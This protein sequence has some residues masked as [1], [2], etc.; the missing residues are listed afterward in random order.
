MKTIVVL[1]DKELSQK[2]NAINQDITN[3]GLR[4]GLKA[5]GLLMTGYVK[6]NI[7]EQKLVD[8]GN[9]LNS[10][11]LKDVALYDGGGYVNVGT[12]VVYARIHEFGGVIKPVRAKMLSWIDKETGK[13]IFAHK[14]VIP[15]RPYMRPAIESHK[16]DV[17][18]TVI[19]YLKKA[20][21]GHAD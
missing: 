19:Y 20:V 11:G 17:A 4:T 5:G 7:V 9:L 15:A 13:R 8:T 10:I 1:G 6:R 12:N 3:E 16:D 2:L 14:A 18:K 21:M